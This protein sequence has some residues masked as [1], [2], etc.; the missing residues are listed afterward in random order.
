PK[1]RW[2]HSGFTPERGVEGGFRIETHRQCD[3]Q[4]RAIGSL[5]QQLPGL[6]DPVAVYQLVEIRP[7]FLV[8]DLGNVVRLFADGAAEGTQVEK[9]VRANRGR[10]EGLLQLALDPFAGRRVQT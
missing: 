5:P 7:K 10:R 9:A 6:R 4:H 2:C 1:S 3:L 8:N